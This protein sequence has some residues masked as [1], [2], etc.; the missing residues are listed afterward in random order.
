MSKILLETVVDG[1]RFAKPL[2]QTYLM[3]MGMLLGLPMH[4][5]MQ[6]R[7]S[8]QPV[9]EDYIPL[10]DGAQV[11]PPQ[12]VRFVGMVWWNDDV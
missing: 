7:K 1:K 8:K 5:Y 10:V 3:F 9:M 4:Y 6:Y 2:F 12:K 11:V